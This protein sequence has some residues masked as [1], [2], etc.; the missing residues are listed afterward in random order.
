MLVFFIVHVSVGSYT[1][2]QPVITLVYEYI[3]NTGRVNGKLAR[4]IN[5]FVYAVYNV[6]DCSHK[7]VDGVELTHEQIN[8]C[9]L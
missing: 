7:V 9:T 6:T 2:G 1:Y 3:L 4:V 8:V 5:V